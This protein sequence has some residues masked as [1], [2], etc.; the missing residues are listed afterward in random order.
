MKKFKI[1]ADFLPSGDQPEAIKQLS[2]NLIAGEKLQT[3]M[4]VTGSGK[5]YTMA[6]IIEK[7]QKPTLII[8][9]NKT[10]AAQLYREFKDF[11]PDNAVEYFVSYYDY[12]QP[13][14]YVAARDL[15]IEKDA[16]INDEIDKMRLAATSA[17]MDRND[18]IIVSSVSCIYGLGNPDDYKNL[19]V[20]LENGMQLD[21]DALIK[22]FINIQ[23]NRDD[24]VL[25]RAAFRVRGDTIDLFPAYSNTGIRIEFWGDNID[26]IC[27]I[28]LINNSILEEV[29]KITIFPA[30]HFV[31]TK[32]T[33]QNVIPR[34]REEL[35]ERIGYLRN[36]GK[37]LEAKRLQ[38]K[39]E[40]DLDMM[41]EIGYCKGIENYSR[42]FSNR[43]QGERPSTLID[44]FPQDFLL[45][46][47][48]SHVTV[49]QI[50]GMFE[51][52]RARKTSLI[53]YGFR[54]PSALDNRPLYFNEFE[55]L[56]NQ[57][58][59]VTATPRDFERDNSSHIVEQ[60][61]RPTGLIDPEII[62]KP[63]EGQIDDL[64]EQIEVVIEREQRILVTT[65]TKKMAED[66]TRYLSE[67]GIRVR[68]LHSEIETLERVEIL[69]D[70]RSGEFDV[71]VGIN[72]LRE[73]L[74]IPEVA[75]VAIMDADKIGFL[76]SATSLIQ[77]IGRAARNVMGKVIMYAD[78]Y[79]SAMQEAI[80]ETNRRRKIQLEYNEKNNI[81]PKTIIKK[82]ENILE[83]KK[84]LEIREEQF[85]LEVLKKRF[86]F[87]NPDDRKQYLKIL[88]KEMLESA[89]NLEFEKAAYLRDEIKNFKDKHE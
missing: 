85:E 47:D 39:T 27:R 78:K 37:E 49:P 65:L 72:L 10:L 51:G 79:S 38:S 20:V 54:L 30:K 2:N 69:R 35:N 28:D 68:Y 43:K 14:A 42:Y 86:N 71:L 11:F 22:Q 73:G 26:K 89:K 12:Y 70:L 19:S 81:K 59:F 25:Q 41:A 40:Y 7:V 23:Y 34:I 17:L 75:L 74:D 87:F 5:T 84:E 46:I 58:V 6:N 53:E 44:F 63:T 56:I 3:L 31:T 16:S 67:K 1:K 24:N 33:L 61:I 36:E 52:D 50:G 88:E 45:F 4:G 60:I 64:L 18:V 83:R 15:Y 80:E 77:T 76:R 57:A 32:E 48:E 21:R 9:H 66:L 55:S 29:D 8:S 82:V 13:E 62:V